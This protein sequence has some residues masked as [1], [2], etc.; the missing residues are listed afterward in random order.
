MI[1]QEVRTLLKFVLETDI[2][3]I[4]TFTGY[5]GDTVIKLILEVNDDI[6]KITKFAKNLGFEVRQDYEMSG[7]YGGFYN[8]FISF[9]HKDIYQLKPG[10]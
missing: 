6:P 4:K 5:K 2:L 9:E 7:K 1:V 8:I 3:H 10:V